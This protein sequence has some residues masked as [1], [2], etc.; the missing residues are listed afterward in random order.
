MRTTRTTT[1]TMMSKEDDK[2]DDKDGD[3][4]DDKDDN[5]DD[6]DD[7]T[8]TTM[9]TTKTMQRHQKSKTT[10]MPMMTKKYIN[11]MLE[12]VQKIPGTAGP[13]PGCTKITH[14]K[15]Y[16]KVL[17]LHARRRTKNTRYCLFAPSHLALQ[18]QQK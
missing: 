16:K 10:M 3:K 1:T 17:K 2:D 12:D 6:K 15:T 14:K 11:Y 8:M 18:Q 5:K 7:V 9:M 4:D 13:Q